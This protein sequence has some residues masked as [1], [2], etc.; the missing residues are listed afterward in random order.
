[1]TNGSGPL[2]DLLRDHTVEARGLEPLTPCLQSRCATN[3]AMPPWGVQLWVP[4]SVSLRPAGVSSE[5]VAEL[6][7]ALP[8]SFSRQARTPRTAATLAAMATSRTTG[9]MMPPSPAWC[10]LGTAWVG[11]P[12][13]EL[14]TSSL[15][16]KRS[17][18]LSYT[19]SCPGK[20]V[21]GTRIHNTP[22][23][24][25]VKI[26]NRSGGIVEQSDDL[27]VGEGHADATDEGGRDV[28]QHGAEHAQRRQQ[29]HVDHGD[30]GRE[31]GDLTQ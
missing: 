22:A 25:P 26:G 23:S 28:V 27:V 1:M 5:S 19:P 31:G 9:F 7:T 15:S 4:A 14:G 17:N 12:R 13:L 20:T 8:R 10:R 24:P 21:P 16:A 18:R 29:H 11:V 6:Q 2:F 3:C 30:D